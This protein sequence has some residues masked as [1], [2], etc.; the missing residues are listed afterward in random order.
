MASSNTHTMLPHL[1]DPLPYDPFRDF[2]PVA[3]FSYTTKM[4]VVSNAVNAT[5]LAELVG[6]AV[7]GRSAANGT[8]PAG[9]GRPI[10]SEP[11][12]SRAPRHPAGCTCHAVP[13]KGATP[14][15][16]EIQC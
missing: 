16:G 13:R 7:T 12:C 5:T 2:A 15:R 10:T 8:A 6:V 1:I 9:I 4:I 11:R 14:A 3:N